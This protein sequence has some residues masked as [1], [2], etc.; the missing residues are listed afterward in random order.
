MGLDY[1]DIY[2]CH[3]FDAECPVEETLWALDDLVAKG[4]IL[5][6][7]VSEWTAAQIANAA[8]ISERRGFRPLV[9]N[10]PIYNMFERYIEEEV[11]PISE[12]AGIGQ[13]VFSPL[14]GGTLT[15]KYRPGQPPP[16]DSRG[17]NDGINFIVKSYLRDDV[18][19][20]TRK[21]GVLA[22]RNGIKLSQMA[23]AWTLRQPNVC[24][25]LIGATKPEQ[26]EEN[27]AGA[28]I[29]LSPETLLEIDTILESV[30]GFAPLR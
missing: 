26:V 7:G 17:A 3:R 9:A 16:K 21:L 24:T 13:V 19:E 1:I 15:G 14:A 12:Q 22:D 6:P 8:G 4:K 23:I 11:I 28:E 30:K 18:L 10:Q 27:A 25:A 29:E 5:Y 2:F 20:C